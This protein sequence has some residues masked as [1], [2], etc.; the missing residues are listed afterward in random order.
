MFNFKVLLNP[1]GE[2][3]DDFETNWA[4]CKFTT[5]KFDQF[6]NAKNLSQLTGTFIYFKYF[7]ILD[8]NLQV[9]FSIVDDCYGKLPPLERDTFW[10]DVTPQPH[11]T[12]ESASRPHNP[13]IGS[14]NN[15]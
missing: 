1:L 9:G 12:A 2:D 14:C 3:D 8:R 4:S 15:V 6:L 13:M 5:M 11:Y 10:H 7:K